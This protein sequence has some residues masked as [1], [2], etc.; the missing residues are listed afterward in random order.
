MEP[1]LPESSENTGIVDSQRRHTAS[2]I[3]T[4]RKIKSINEE[5]LAQIHPSIQ[6]AFKEWYDTPPAYGNQQSEALTFFTNAYKNDRET[7]PYDYTIEN[8]RNVPY[9]EN[10]SLRSSA[11]AFF[12]YDVSKL[13][14]G[15]FRRNIERHSV[16]AKTRH[17]IERGDDAGEKRTEEP[18]FS[19]SSSSIAIV[20]GRLSAKKPAPSQ[21]PKSILKRALASPKHDPTGAVSKD[22]TG[23]LTT[24]PV[25]SENII[26]GSEAPPAKRVKFLDD[27]SESHTG[28]V[29]SEASES[30]KPPKRVKFLDNDSES[31]TGAVASEASESAKPLADDDRLETPMAPKTTLT[32]QETDFR[33]MRKLERINE[34]RNLTNPNYLPQKPEAQ[35]QIRALDA[36]VLSKWAKGKDFEGPQH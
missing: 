23:A 19:P 1:S 30:A 15:E 17:N 20:Q 25:S 11:I 7:S 8:F 2:V 3:S 14:N 22:E 32:S 10:T 9:N 33:E 36:A 13:T 18:A 27:D 34:L 4:D 6:G 35:S 31:H 24:N 16:R 29:A 12:K 21:V 26:E 28:A 5:E